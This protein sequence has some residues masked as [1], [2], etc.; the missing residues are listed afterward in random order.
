MWVRRTMEEEEEG[1]R[2]EKKGVGCDVT[3]SH[4]MNKRMIAAAGRI[5]CAAE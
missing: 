5:G 2:I 1:R 4:D 3:K